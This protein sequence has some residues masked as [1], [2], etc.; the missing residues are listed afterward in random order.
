MAAECTGAGETHNHRMFRPIHGGRLQQALHT[1]ATRLPSQCTVCRTWP[2]EPVCEACVAQFAQPL[3]R[4]GTCALPLPEGAPHC[5]ACLAHPPPLDACFAAVSYGYPW[6]ELITSFKFKSHPGWARAM[7]VLLRSMPFV[8]P[9]LD[10]ADWVLPLPLSQQRLQAR[11]YNQAW[12]LAC[13]L[14]PD[15]RRRDARLLLRIADTAPQSGLSRAAR[16]RNLRSAF[17]VDPLRSTL[18]KAR[19]IVLVDDVMTSGATLHAA[20]LALRAAGA[21][22]ITGLVF[23]RTDAPS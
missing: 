7:A 12:E 18:L 1:L 8:E 17:A 14:A 11:G 3:A 23:A 19:R 10:Q 2:S 9:A 22:H 21:S 16:L 5:V 4:C 6:S 20:A 13:Q 15:K